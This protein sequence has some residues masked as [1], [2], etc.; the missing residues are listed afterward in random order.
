MTQDPRFHDLQTF[1]SVVDQMQW[2]QVSLEPDPAVV[3]A[4]DLEIPSEWLQLLDTPDL[5]AEF[6]QEVLGPLSRMT[7]EELNTQVRE[8]ISEL[9]IDVDTIMRELDSPDLGLDQSLGHDL[10]LDFGR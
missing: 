4:I 7:D 2:P 9:D 10:D 5:E 8:V 3:E 6:D 1:Q